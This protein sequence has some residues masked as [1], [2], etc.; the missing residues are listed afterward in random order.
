MRMQP[1][2]SDEPYDGNRLQRFMDMD[3]AEIRD[4]IERMQTGAVPPTVN[5]V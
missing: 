3:R 1:P 2:G 5:Q 4:V